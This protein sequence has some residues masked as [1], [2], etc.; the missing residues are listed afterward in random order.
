MPGRPGLDV[1]SVQTRRYN[2]KLEFY[3]LWY[4]TLSHLYEE[5]HVTLHL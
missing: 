3:R 2:I 1:R 5:N 4:M